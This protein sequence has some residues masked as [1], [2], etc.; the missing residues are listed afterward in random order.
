MFL[1]FGF[2]DGHENLFIYEFED[3]YHKES[4]GSIYD[5]GEDGSEFYDKQIAEGRRRE[6]IAERLEKRS[7][8]IVHP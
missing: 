4:A 2:R 3:A 6:H 8:R 7:A 5:H 1:V